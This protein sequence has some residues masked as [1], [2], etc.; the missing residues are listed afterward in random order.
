M[1]T[2]FELFKGKNFK[3]LCR[4]IYSNQE[5]RKEQIEVL[6]S[7][8]RPLVKKVEDAMIIVPLI[9]DYLNVSVSNDEHLVR[10]AAIIQ[11]IMTANSQIP[12]GGPVSITDQE[13]KEIMAQ[14][15]AIKKQSDSI[16]V[17]K[18]TPKGE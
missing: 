17:K 2:D 13:R 4:D 1:D 18:I 9:K 10:L 15:D 3:D 7:E 11:K 14:V 5:T 6:I 8:L 16:T 12:E